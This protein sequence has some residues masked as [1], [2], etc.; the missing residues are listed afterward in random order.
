MLSEI[1]RDLT[2]AVAGLGGACL[3]LQAHELAESSTLQSF[4]E[5]HTHKILGNAPEWVRLMG[6]L[7]AKK[8][9][10]WVVPQH[11]VSSSQAEAAYLLPLESPSPMPMA[12]LDV[13][14][15]LEAN[16]VPEEATPAATALPVTE[17]TTIIP[18]A[19][20]TLE[21]TLVTPTFKRSRSDS[22]SSTRKFKRPKIE[23]EPLEEH[24][25]VSTTSHAS[26]KD[27]SPVSSQAKKNPKTAAATMP[28]TPRPSV[29]SSSKRDGKKKSKSAYVHSH[30]DAM[31]NTIVD[32]VP[33][34]DPMGSGCSDCNILDVVD[35]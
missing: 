13:P 32:T 2:G 3:G 20:V 35:S 9:H 21:T 10:R 15:P 8:V 26:S 22:V 14:R 7:A 25:A 19:E 17:A 31:N 24:H 18:E 11:A 4:V 29:L 23:P 33:L 5:R 34:P 30:D 12:M 16:S 1:Q 28:D 27:R 6:L